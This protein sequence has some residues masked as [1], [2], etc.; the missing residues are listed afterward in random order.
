MIRSATTRV[1]NRWCKDSVRSF[2]AVFIGLVFGLT[3]AR[4]D[5]SV[6]S[7]TSEFS[8]GHRVEHRHLVLRSFNGD[9]A[10]LD[11]AIFLNK[12]A[13]LRVIDDREADDG[14]AASMQ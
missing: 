4:A 13:A 14:L 11:L 8:S 6:A 5:W 12:D 7:T 2:S 9:E 10:D 1:S 3:S